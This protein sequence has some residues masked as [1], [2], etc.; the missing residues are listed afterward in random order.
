MKK[1]EKKRKADCT[2]GSLPGLRI[3]KITKKHT[4][5]CRSFEAPYLSDIKQTEYKLVEK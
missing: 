2:F 3:K 1:K 4:I 5:M